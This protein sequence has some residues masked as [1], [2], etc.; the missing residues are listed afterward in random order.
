MNQIFLILFAKEMGLKELGRGGD[1]VRINIYLK[2]FLVKNKKL[3][4]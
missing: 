2:D 3:C 1:N 4:L